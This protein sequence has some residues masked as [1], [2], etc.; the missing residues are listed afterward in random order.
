MGKKH[1]SDWQNDACGEY[2]TRARLPWPQ[3]LLLL[4][5]MPVKMRQSLVHSRAWVTWFLTASILLVSVLAWT[6]WHE[7]GLWENLV[8]THQ[9]QGLLWWV[10][11]AGYPFLHGDWLHLL[12]N[13]YFLLVFGRNIECAFGRRRML[14][15]FLFSSMA[16]GL[17]HTLF[18]TSG[19]IGA[20]GGV[21]GL[22]VFYVL[23][24]PQARVMWLPLGLAGRLVSLV[25][26]REYLVKGFAVWIYLLL[27][28][29]LQL[30]ILWEQLYGQGQIS[31]LAHIG[32]GVAGLIIWWGW[33]KGWLP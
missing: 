2:Q 4:V 23:Q 8:L 16:G 19:L 5:G 27:F 17:L 11:L 31:A 13:L 7:P 10:G 25:L 29:S 9:H 18:S 6:Q 3:M 26:F 12:G 30:F 22:L 28:G 15:L 20:S 1:P 14:W 21:F 32:G 33:R 24:F